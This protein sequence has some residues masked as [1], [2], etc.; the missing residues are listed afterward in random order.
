MLLEQVFDFWSF[1]AGQRPFDGEACRA[2][3]AAVSGT[4]EIWHELEQ[5]AD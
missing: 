1:G 4:T 2:G 3:D 5:L